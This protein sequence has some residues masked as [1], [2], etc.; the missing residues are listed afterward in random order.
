VDFSNTG[1]L[2]VLI[3]EE[4]VSLAEMLMRRHGY[5]DGKYIAAVL[6]FLRSDSQIWWRF[7]HSYIQGRPIPYSD[8]MFWNHDHT[9]LP[10]AMCSFCL[11]KLCLENRLIAG[12]A[13]SFGGVPVDLR[14]IRQPLYA[15]GALEDHICRWESTFAVCGAVTGP[16]R[17]VLTAGGHITG[18]V[19]PPTGTSGAKFWA[20]DATGK[21]SAEPWLETVSPSPGSWWPDWTRWLTRFDRQQVAHP[22]GNSR[23]PVLEKAP[24]RYV[25]EK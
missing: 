14:S 23:Y 5:L 25:L 21:T 22:L 8:F 24:G 7:A 11:R 10:E 3:T 17:Y 18:I 12:D 20:E 19:N 13:L 9:R 16:V 6:N 1:S 15:V 2:E 4:T